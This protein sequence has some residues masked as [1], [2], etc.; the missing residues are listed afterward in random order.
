MHPRPRVPA[1]FTLYMVDVFCCALG[2]VILLWLVNAREA[3]RKG[4]VAEKHA[5]QLAAARVRL[6]S[7]AEELVGL[8]AARLLAERDRD[9]L[10]GQL[11]ATRKQRDALARR[12]AEAEQQHTAARRTLAQ[13][14]AQVAQLRADLKAADARDAAR[15]VRLKEAEDRARNLQRQAEELRQAVRDYRAQLAALDSRVRAL[16]RDLERRSADLTDTGQRL[17]DLEEAKGQLERRLASHSQDADAARKHVAALEERTR[18]LTRQLRTQ[19]AEADK[20]FAGIT[21]TGR[22]AVF[23]VDRSGSMGMRD[24]RTADG[25]KWPRVSAVLAR[26][27]ESLPDLE[28]YQVILFSDRVAYPLGKDRQWL[29][30]DRRTSPAEVSRR[31]QQVTPTGETNLYAA[32]AEAFHYRSKGLDTIYLLSDGLPSAG[33]GAPVGKGGPTGPERSA[34]LG[35][36]V[37][38]TL[39]EDWN[40]TFPGLPRVRINTIGFYYDS[41]AVGAFLWALAREHDGSFVGLSQP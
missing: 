37:R 23:L 34:Q 17:R 27:M 2:C 10:K 38:Q 4:N 13:S 14:Q 3:R 9:R 22:R 21:L 25:Q 41:P 24:A 26:L 11:L 30:Y 32:F 7:A 35:R 29:I 6:E 31:V 19:R 5:T 18:D 40:R 36:H 20:R 39:R 15:G 28:R 16:D 8:R 1:V 12:T 33:E